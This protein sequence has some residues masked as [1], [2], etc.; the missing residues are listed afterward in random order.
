MCY[1]ADLPQIPIQEGAAPAAIPKMPV[2]S[3]VRLN[4]G[5]RPTISDMMPQNNAP[6]HKPKNNDSVVN[7][8]KFSSIP[9]S[10][11]MDGRVSATV[12]SPI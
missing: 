6:I 4:A 3:N 1:G 11:D 10:F 2:P 8:T 12:W 5:R 7:L 9:N